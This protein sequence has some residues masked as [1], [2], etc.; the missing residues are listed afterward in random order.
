MEK[1]SNVSSTLA[2]LCVEKTHRCVDEDVKTRGLEKLSAK[3][4]KE[5]QI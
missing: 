5:I 3:Q 4:L 1:K 2:C